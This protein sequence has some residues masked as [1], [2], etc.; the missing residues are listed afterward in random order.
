V[1]KFSQRSVYIVRKN[2]TIQV[3]AVD[4][5]GFRK[6]LKKEGKSQRVTEAAIAR[7]GEF[8][9][10]MKEQ[11]HGKE[12]DKAR[13]EDLDGF[14]S[15]IE[16]DEDMAA[17][18]FLLGI[19]YFYE[20]SPNTEMSSHA[21][22]RWNERMLSSGMPLMLKEFR[23]ISHE[24][25]RKLENAGIRKVNDMINAGQTRI[26][27]KE[28]SAKTGVPLPTILELT[29]LSDLTRIQGVKGTRAR[30]YYDAGVDTM[31]KMAK[32]NPEE[33]REMLIKFIQKT[34]FNG[35][36]PLPKE[37]KNTIEMARRMPR[38]VEY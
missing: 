34:R 14:I 32:W 18:K 21:S 23:G 27:R 13:P 10:Y 15:W 1:R 20:F 28:L 33:L 12:L 16:K 9:R 22:F 4:K 8:E 38:I 31:K 19:R 17:K 37:A 35:I 25:L 2:K 24:D 7:V 29:K 30:L 11:K 3:K 26:R 6:Y 36:A 5:D